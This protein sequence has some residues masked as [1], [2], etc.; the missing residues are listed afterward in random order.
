MLTTTDSGSAGQDIL[1]DELT[2]LVAGRAARDLVFTTVNGEV[3]RNRNAR[4]SWFD[5]AAA[6]IGEA[7]LTPHE[8]R[9]TAASLAEVGGIASDAS[10]DNP[11][12]RR[13]VRALAHEATMAAGRVGPNRLPVKRCLGRM[14]QPQRCGTRL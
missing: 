8:L 11:C 6:A 3:L 2:T 7:G 10:F 1:V 13:I 4:R 5:R 14:Q 9:H 12:D